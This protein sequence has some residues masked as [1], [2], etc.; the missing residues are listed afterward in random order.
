MRKDK[1]RHGIVLPWREQGTRHTSNR[2]NALY[3]LG[4]IYPSTA[5]RTAMILTGSW[6]IQVAQ[7]CESA[8]AECKDGRGSWR[9][10]VFAHKN[11][12]PPTC[13]IDAKL[14][15]VCRTQENGV[16]F[17]PSRVFTWQGVTDS[18]MIAT[19]EPGS[20]TESRIIMTSSHLASLY[21]EDGQLRIIVGCWSLS[22][23]R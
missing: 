9:G 11:H 5:R 3:S 13:S 8:S 21:R 12:V 22:H 1:T 7:V 4:R 18:W 17:C 10:A 15:M 19:S 23:L 6:S 14:T 16:H 2:I 20:A